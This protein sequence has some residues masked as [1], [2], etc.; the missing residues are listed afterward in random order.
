MGERRRLF[1]NQPQG[2]ALRR[3]DEVAWPGPFRRGTDKRR[4]VRGQLSGLI[5]KTVLIDAI[6]P[7]IGGKH[8]FTARIGGDHMRMRAVV[9]ADGETA[10]NSRFRLR[11]ARFAPILMGVRSL[12]QAAVC[13]NGQHRDSSADVVCHQQVFAVWRQRKIDRTG[14]AGG[15]LIQL[16]QITVIPHPQRLHHALLHFACQIQRLAVVRDG[17]L[18][19]V[20]QFAHQRF[21]TQRAGLRIDGKAVQPFAVGIIGADPGVLGLGDCRGSKQRE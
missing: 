13:V 4:I 18:R 20:R 2:I 14:T 15:H 1:V 21:V 9:I 19:G 11:R 5:V 12:T 7:K 16:A 6:Q 10:L 17:Q 3:K 8:V